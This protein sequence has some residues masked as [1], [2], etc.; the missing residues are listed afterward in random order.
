ME[1]HVPIRNQKDC[2]TVRER[3]RSL[4]KRECPNRSFSSLNPAQNPWIFPDPVTSG[5][6]LLEPGNAMEF[7]VIHWY[8]IREE[9]CWLEY[10]KQC[11]AIAISQHEILDGNFSAWKGIREIEHSLKISMQEMEKKRGTNL[12]EAAP[13]SSRTNNK[14][15]QMDS[16]QISFPKFSHRKKC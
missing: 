11:D 10:V 7:C 1:I 9:A 12:N 13:N 8:V 16:N 15:Q 4:G 2:Q 3:K 5:I 14:S 6:W